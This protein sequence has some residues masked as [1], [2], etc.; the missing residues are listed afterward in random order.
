M[1]KKAIN[2]RA[3]REAAGARV[4][5]ISNIVERIKRDPNRHQLSGVEVGLC[6]AAVQVLD[7]LSHLLT[8]GRDK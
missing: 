3:R 4:E 5:R 7:E 1:V 2:I 8:I 6:H